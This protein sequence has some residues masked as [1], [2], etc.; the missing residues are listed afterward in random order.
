ME[1]DFRSK[2]VSLFRNKFTSKIYWPALMYKYPIMQM[3]KPC[4][5]LVIYVCMHAHMHLYSVT[6]FHIVVM[7]FEWGPWT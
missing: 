7:I 1:V 6:D 5:Y 3:K 2:A 4:F